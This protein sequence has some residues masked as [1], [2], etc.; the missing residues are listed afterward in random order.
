MKSDHWRG[1]LK[2]WKR[3]L[4]LSQAKPQNNNP[5]EHNPP[6]ALKG[7]RMI[8]E[9]YPDH[10]IFPVEWRSHTSWRTNFKGS[11]SSLSQ[12]DDLAEG[13]VP[14]PSRYLG[15]I[16]HPTVQVQY[17]GDCLDLL[18]QFQHKLSSG[19]KRFIE[20]SNCFSRHWKNEGLSIWYVLYSFVLMGARGRYQ[21]MLLDRLIFFLFEDDLCAHSSWWSKDF[22]ELIYFIKKGKMCVFEGSVVKAPDD[23][24]APTWWRSQIFCEFIHLIKK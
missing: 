18:T 20:I 8:E 6:R 22:C 12:V 15:V 7:G 9:I 13:I 17:N 5:N 2:R 19:K 10:T 3:I 4:N 16:F 21:L 23:S 11:L 1:M 24:C 14:L